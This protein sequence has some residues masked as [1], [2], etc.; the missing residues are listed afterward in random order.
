MKASSCL[1]ALAL[2][3]FMAF[4]NSAMAA[5]AGM[6]RTNEIPAWQN[7]NGAIIYVLESAAAEARQR[8][9]MNKGGRE[10]LCLMKNVELRE[11]IDRLEHGGQ[12]TLQEIVDAVDGLL[13]PRNSY[14]S[15]AY[16]RCE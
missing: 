3:V 14:E 11:L 10:C 9:R 1:V 8:A 12:V 2:F 15:V 5:V 16:A 6:A 7:K 4:A 13:R